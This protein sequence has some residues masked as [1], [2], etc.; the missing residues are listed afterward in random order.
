MKLGTNHPWVKGKE[1]DRLQSGD[2]N[3]NGKKENSRH[4]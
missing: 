3:K 2:K 4:F 1:P